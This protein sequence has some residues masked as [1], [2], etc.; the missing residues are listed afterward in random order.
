MNSLTQEHE[1]LARNF[2][3]T[4]IPERKYLNAILVFAASNKKGTCQKIAM[5]TGIPMGQS[6]GKVKAILGYSIGMGL[7]KLN[8]KSSSSIKEPILT[9]LG[10][11]VLLED[12]FLK[13]R[14]TQ[15]LVHLNLSNPKAGADI[16]FQVFCNGANY[17]G[18]SFSR[19]ELQQYLSN[20]YQSRSAR[21]IGPLITTYKDKA[22]LDKC[23]ALVESNRMIRKISAPIEEEF[24]S[25]YGYWL[26]KIIQDF[27]PTNLQITLDDLDS[28]AGF[29]RI[30]NW[31][32][33]DIRVVLNIIERKG[34]VVVDRHMN[35][36]IIEPKYDYKN[37]SKKIYEGLI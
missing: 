12:P 9:D 27:F 13:E 22:A 36:W 17:L 16:W 1:R 35:P 5:D 34:L 20:I 32:Y 25:A 10:R 21:L 4:F 18:T 14:I 3:Q 33:D 26:L 15:W 30:P 19:K 29:K 31:N 11:I 37:V 23:G 28:Y 2:H 6:S 8:N 24:A 7:L